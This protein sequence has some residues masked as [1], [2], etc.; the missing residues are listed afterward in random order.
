MDGTGVP[1]VVLWPPHVYTDMYVNNNT[2]ICKHIPAYINTHKITVAF[3]N[4][5]LENLGGKLCCTSCHIPH[6][7]LMANGEPLVNSRAQLWS[8][9]SRDLFSKPI[10]SLD[11]AA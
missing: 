1:R 3:F 6:N 5:S 11:A 4:T 10:D 9:L 7:C 2:Q 8:K